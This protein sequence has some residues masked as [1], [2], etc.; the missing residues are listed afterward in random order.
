MFLGL[1]DPHPDP[2]VRGTDPK[3]RIRTKMSQI[4]TLEKGVKDCCWAPGPFVEKT[5]SP[6]PC[7]VDDSSSLHPR[8]GSVRLLKHIVL[9]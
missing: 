5:T 1:P 9:G 3:I 2:L 7:Y 6:L 8:R 4:S